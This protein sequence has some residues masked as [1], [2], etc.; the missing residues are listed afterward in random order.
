MTFASGL[1][2]EHLALRLRPL[3]RALRNAVHR[4]TA[5]AERLLRPDVTPLCVTPDQV[6]TLLGDVEALPGWAG[7]SAPLLPG[8]VIEEERLRSRALA[9][10]G[11]GVGKELPLDRLSRR[12]GL[13]AF[14]EEAVLLCAAPEIDRAYERIYAYVLDDLNRRFPSVEL[15]AS[16]TAASLPERL[17]RRRAL[18]PFGRLRRTGVLEARGEAPTD[19][20]QELRLAPAALEFLLT[21]RGDEKAFGDPDE[22]ELPAKVEIPPGLSRDELER[23][24]RALADGRVAAAGVWGPRH[25][26]RDEGVLVLARE[27][28]LPLRR[29]P[30]DRLAAAGADP[31]SALRAAMV[32][33]AALGA[34]LHVPLDGLAE[35]GRERWE[36]PLAHALAR[37]AVPLLLSGRHPWRPAELLE[38]LPY[39]EVELSPPGFPARQDLW[40]EVFPD[41]DGG[42]VGDLATRYRLSRGEILAVERVART[43][44]HLAGNGQPAPLTDHL[45][46]A[47]RTV[48]RRRSEELA[49]T[50]RPK[51]GPGDL[52]LPP[53]LH[54]QVLEIASFF[55]AGARVDEG[56]GFGRRSRGSGLKALF[57]GESGTGKTLAAEVVAGLLALPLLKVD[58][59]RVVSKW[60]GET[61]KNLESVFREAEESH[62]VLFFD[63]GDALFGKRG[64]VQNGTDRYANLEVSY[65]L[66]KLED[67]AGLLILAS[68]LKDQIDNAF[69]RRFQIALHFPRPA[70]AERRRIWTIAFPPEAPLDPQADLDAL[71]RLDLTGAGIASIARTAALLAADEKSEAITM[72]HLVR[73]T[74]RQY[75]RETRILAPAELGEWA[76]LLG[77]GS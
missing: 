68:N 60:I 75:R 73:A 33:A 26:G 25:A 64:E 15:L 47:C 54:R 29:L 3:H 51:N 19:L 35:A 10:T 2:V 12:L 57:T 72:A 16:L 56:W 37:S 36:A 6:E 31:E 50:V 5:E 40:A 49:S 1:A 21:G 70:Q 32:A 52:V 8:E 4:Q 42:Q 67:H 43:R 24:G 53:A 7:T 9:E 62:S 13:D 18:G 20:R 41:L 44:A 77:E 28:G 22:V 61:E 65:L 11:A 38:A 76:G 66:Q 34:V 23:L 69:T 17:A 39:A 30:L 27:I 63:E 58:L 74:A 71:S 46:A 48:T 55:R 59:A 45:D 14:D